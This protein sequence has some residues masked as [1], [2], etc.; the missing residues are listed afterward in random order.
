MTY[1][2]WQFQFYY[3]A[4]QVQCYYSSPMFQFAWSQSYQ[5]EQELD[6]KH[7]N[8]GPSFEN[9]AN[10]KNFGAEFGVA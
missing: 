9:N 1:Q 7:R 6:V 8:V 10:F 5:A 2:F 4:L 3:S